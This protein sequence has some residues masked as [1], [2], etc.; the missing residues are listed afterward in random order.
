M[1]QGIAI[2]T[3]GLVGLALVILSL[4]GLVRRWRRWRARVNEE[5]ARRRRHKENEKQLRAEIR[6][7]NEEDQRHPLPQVKAMLL[8]FK[9]SGKTVQLVV[10]HHSMCI[11]NDGVRLQPYPPTL[12]GL[13]E[14]VSS[15]LGGS[16]VLPSGNLRGVTTEWQFRVQAAGDRTGLPRTLFRLSYVDFAGERGPEIFKKNPS[17]AG[18]SRR[19]LSHLV[20]EIFGIHPSWARM[21]LC[22]EGGH[23]DNL[24]MIELLRLRC[25]TIY[26]FDASSGGAPLAD[27]LAGTLALAREELGVDITLT[28]Q[29]TL[30]PGGMNP[31]PFRCKQPTRWSQC[32]HIEQRGHRRRHQIPRAGCTTGQTD[33]CPG[34][35]HHQ[36]PVQRTGVLPKRSRIPP[37]QHRG[38]MVQQPAVRRLFR[39]AAAVGAAIR[40]LVRG[41]S[42][43]FDSYNIKRVACLPALS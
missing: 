2:I 31:P 25:G 11:G 38:P 4:R 20:R 30:V 34:S 36:S 3:V 21:L 10:M 40:D 29:F 13:G 12:A 1:G 17:L 42:E 26:C 5:K 27:T 18:P 7:M 35:P 6:R 37:R 9:E 22:T 33:L 14:M 32:P 15:I 43:I 23:Y 41:P 19:R 28:N 39:A 24:G 16:P 8:G